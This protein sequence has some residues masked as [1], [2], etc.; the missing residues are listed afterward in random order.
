MGT[1]GAIER[2]RRAVDVERLVHTLA[3]VAGALILLVII[4]LPLAAVFVKAFQARD[5]SFAG[6]ANFT[7]YFGNPALFRSVWNSVWVAGLATVITVGL[8]FVFAYGLTRTRMRGKTLLQLVAISPLLTPSMLPAISLVYLFGNQGVI[9]D[10][11]MGQSIYG[12]IGLVAGLVYYCFPHALM[13]LVTALTLADQR[14]YEAAEALGT[15]PARIFRTVT[16]PGIRFGLIGAAAV[17]FTLAITDFGV[18][19]VVGG[20]FNVLATDVY[21]QVVGQNNFSMGAVV[22]LV[23]LIPAILSFAVTRAAERRQRAALTARA[24]LFAPQPAS[25]RD[26]VFLVACGLI[27]VVLAVM[28]G[29]S[30]YASLVKLW[31]YDLSLSLISYDFAEHDAD[32]WSSV[33]N[34][35]ILGGGAAA[36]GTVLV[37]VVAY[38]VEKGQGPR[39]L[40]E[41]IRVVALLPMAVPGLVLGIAY[42]FFFNQPA[43][44]LNGLVGGMAILIINTVAHF[45]T[46]A[47]LTAQTAL[48]QIDGEFEAVSASLR[49]PQYKTMLRVTVPLCLPT[50]ISIFGYMFANALTTA[51]ALIFLYGPDTKVASVAVI[52]MDDAG[53]VGPAA[54]MAMVIVYC[55][56]AVRL[57]TAGLN[58][59]VA[60]RLQRW[61][62]R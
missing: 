12:P 23:L 27:A 38:L 21:K 26:T 52:A 56:V 47:H 31:P 32:G 18:A 44:P 53:N 11:L 48:K 37:F 25:F 60:G 62:Q 30:A 6:L 51:S 58:H 40:R 50:L 20:R 16:L 35:L 7:A 54:A 19:K 15:R 55:A 17:T 14:L 42:V 46:V 3:T 45:Y 9:K 8:A 34:S 39:G 22:G 5:G 13:I 24:V 49:V 2:P 43:N 29:M 4:V 10:W 61:R 57:I 1:L 28:L 36:V 33:W 59:L 41:A